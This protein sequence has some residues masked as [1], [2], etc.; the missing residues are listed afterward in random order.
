MRFIK[1]IVTVL[2]V[3]RFNIII[4]GNNNHQQLVILI[5]ALQVKYSVTYSHNSKMLIC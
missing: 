2:A 5:V 3:L 4:S 1:A